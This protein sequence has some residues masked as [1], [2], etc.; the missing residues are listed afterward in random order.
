M[1]LFPGLAAPLLPEILLVVSR[2]ARDS[3]YSWELDSNTYIPSNSRSIAKQFI[4]CV[5]HQLSGNGIFWM[6]FHLKLEEDHRYL[7]TENIYKA[8]RTRIH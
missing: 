2:I 6:I 3:Q 1:L 8:G 7:D 4:R 5:L